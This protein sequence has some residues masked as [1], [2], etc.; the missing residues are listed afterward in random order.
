MQRGVQ[1]L[2]G[3]A[4][5]KNTGESAMVALA[6]LKAEVPA[7][8]PWRSG[9]RRENQSTVRGHQLQ[10]R[11]APGPG[12]Y[13]AAATAMVLANLDAEGNRPLISA[14]A[15]YLSSNQNANGSWDYNGR[16]RETPRSRNTVC[17]GSGSARTPGAEVPP[18]VW[19]RAASWY[20]SV[21]ELG[22]KLELP[23]R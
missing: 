8:D 9:V 10:A 12:T 15:S 1:Y 14:V 7:T 21:Q 5:N 23:S 18:S 11:A 22:R 13:E 19:D 16:S 20:L 6:F 4:G 2:R 17:S 3:S